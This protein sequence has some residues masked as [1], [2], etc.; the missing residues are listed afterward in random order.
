[1]VVPVPW[2]ISTHG[3]KLTFS[4]LQGHVS[5]S[6]EQDEQIP[7]LISLMPMVSWFILHLSTSSSFLTSFSILLQE[8]QE[9]GGVFLLSGGR[10]CVFSFAYFG[11]LIQSPPKCWCQTVHLV[12]NST[13]VSWQISLPYETICSS[14]VPSGRWDE[15]QHIK[16][17]V[18]KTGLLMSSCCG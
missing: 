8:C 7:F 4:K 11:L 6:L 17:H 12:P 15:T 2:F 18:R 10:L 13:T 14:K 3:G 5:H 16:I 1:M 9:L